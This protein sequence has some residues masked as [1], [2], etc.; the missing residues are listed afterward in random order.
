MEIYLHKELDNMI[1]VYTVWYL[2][3]DNVSNVTMSYY[4]QVVAVEN[5]HGFTFIAPSFWNDN[6]DF[7][8]IGEL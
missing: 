7:E 8:L 4:D 2:H 1:I 6:N 3:A 5:K